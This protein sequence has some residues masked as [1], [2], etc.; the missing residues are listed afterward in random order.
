MCEQPEN[1]LSRQRLHR[2]CAVVTL[3]HEPKLDD[4]ALK[5]ALQSEAFYIGAL[6]S[7]KTHA[8]RLERLAEAGLSGREI[9][10]LHAPVGLDIG[11]R[12]APEIA[13]AIIAEITRCRRQPQALQSGG[14][15][16]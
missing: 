15:L 9:G 3:S 6:G 4:P 16:R 14:A 12:N 7:S 10:R 8:R 5:I 13:I 2:R 1:A 11:A